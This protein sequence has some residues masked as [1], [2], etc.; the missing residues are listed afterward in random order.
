[1]LF[2]CPID[3]PAL[4]LCDMEDN[5][6][7]GEV[8]GDRN[9]HIEDGCLSYHRIGTDRCRDE[10]GTDVVRGME[11]DGGFEASCLEG[12]Y[13]CDEA[14]DQD[15]EKS[16]DVVGV[17][18]HEYDG[19]EHKRY[20]GYGDPAAEGLHEK[21]AEGIFLRCRLHRH[22]DQDREEVGEAGKREGGNLA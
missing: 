20:H 3:E 14:E 12:Q 13:S 7:D 1:M 2:F 17:R 19:L 9:R 10:E 22:E 4:L 6:E 5:Q 11:D 8:K 21:A 18:P 16:P 15:G